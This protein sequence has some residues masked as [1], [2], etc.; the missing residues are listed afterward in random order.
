MAHSGHP[1]YER[2]P[3]LG[4]EIMNMSDGLATGALI[5]Q[6][7]R[8]NRSQLSHHP[9]RSSIRGGTPKRILWGKTGIRHP[10]KFGFQYR[11]RSKHMQCLC[12]MCAVVW[13]CVIQKSM[14]QNLGH[15]PLGGVRTITR[16]RASWEEMRSLRTS[17]RRE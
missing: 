16:G 2:V 6:H 9:R 13:I 17:Q 7:I 3:S 10:C 8:S 4:A 15:Q 1:E 12:Y 14:C 5:D 11:Q